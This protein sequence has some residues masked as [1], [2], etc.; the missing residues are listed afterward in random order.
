VQVLRNIFIKSVKRSTGKFTSIFL[1]RYEK[2]YYYISFF[3]HF[4]SILCLAIC[5]YR[6]YLMNMQLEKCS[7]L[8]IN[9]C[10]FGECLARLNMN[11]KYKWICIFL[12]FLFFYS[13]PHN[14]MFILDRIICISNPQYFILPSMQKNLM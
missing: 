12:I 8:K 4:I 5:Q 2:L 1:C 9:Y 11:T 14:Y 3:R 6:T 7:Y 13:F 10:K